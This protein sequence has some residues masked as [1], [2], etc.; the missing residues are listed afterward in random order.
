MFSNE[1]RWSTNTAIH[2]IVETVR[3]IFS[4]FSDFLFSVRLFLLSLF[5]TVTPSS[6]LSTIF[7]ISLWVFLSLLCNVNSLVAN[8]KLTS[9]NLLSLLIL[10]SIL[11]A[12]C[13]QFN[14]SNIN[15]YFIIP[16]HT[17]LYIQRNIT[18]SL[19]LVL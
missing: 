10:F 15:S 7:C 4:K 12:Q 8:V 2:I 1:N 16:S 6:M 3:R 13:A 9:S 14:P 17:F 11:P 5:T 19:R 18:E